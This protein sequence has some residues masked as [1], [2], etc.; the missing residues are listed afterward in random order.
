MALNLSEIEAVTNDYFAAA[1]GKA[2]D[3]YFGSS[4]LLDFL[5]NRRMGLFERPAG[6]EK[7]RIPLNYSDAEGGFFTRAD[8]LSSD[9]RASVSAAFFEWKHAYG[10]ATVYLTDE[11]A[12]GGDYAAVQ[13][14]TQKIET[15]QKTCANWLAATLYSAGGDESPT[16]TGLRALTGGDPDVLYGGIAENQLVA[17]DGSRPWRAV[18]LDEAA[19]MGL[20]VLQNMRSAAKISD[21]RDGKPNVAVTTEAL[22]NK[23]SRI[24]QV[25]QRFVSDDEAARAGFTHLVFEGMILA[26]DD[27]CPA[28]HAFAVNTN[29]LGFAI[30]QNGFFSRRPW[31]ELDG[32]AGKTMKILWHGNLVCSNRKAHA[33]HANLS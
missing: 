15:A 25:Q 3:I 11:I 30:H 18:T 32:P 4:F 29:H 10:N 17:A 14:V 19:P 6:G 31:T 27:F 26:A 5:M 20:D 12:A 22:Y 9:D 13:F 7:I 28:G 21:G 33:A 24:L 8:P 23:I 1:D 2:V 16:L